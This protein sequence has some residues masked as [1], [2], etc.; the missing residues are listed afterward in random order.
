MKAEDGSVTKGEGNEE[1]GKHCKF[2]KITGRREITWI[3]I[4]HFD[5]ISKTAVPKKLRYLVDKF[6]TR[7]SDLKDSVGGKMWFY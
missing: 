4:N 7:I 2:L 6:T 1:E 3:T 5:Y